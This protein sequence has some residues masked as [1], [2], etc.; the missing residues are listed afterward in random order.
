MNNIQAI[1]LQRIYA[2]PNQPRKHFD[3]EK[4]E[5]LAQSIKQYGVMEPIVVTPRDDR[6]MIIAGE[7]RF[8][9]STIAELQEIPACVLIADDEL[10][11]ELALLEN[12]QRQDLNPIEEAKAFQSLLD[13]GWDKEKLAEKM[14]FKQPWRI[15]ERTSLL[16][17]D[18]VYQKMVVEGKIGNS[19]AFE[20]SRVPA[21]QQHIV[22][23]QIK[24]GKLDSYNKVRSFVD[25]LLKLQEQASIFEFQILT[26]EEKGAIDGFNTMLKSCE[27]FIAACYGDKINH[28]KKAV[29]H[30]IQVERLDMVINGL[31]KIRK[32]VLTGQGIKDAMEAAG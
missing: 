12:V 25:G 14:G 22:F 26:L 27:R 20:M 5:E 9:A 21:D 31:M 17:L 4:L 6:Y 10:V 30:D 29:F 23:R 11:E 2:N 15:D 32:M 13:R 24:A 8:R 3:Q 18:P 16:N 7:R 1:P 28:L 19:Q